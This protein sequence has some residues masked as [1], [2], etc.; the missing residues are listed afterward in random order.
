MDYNALSCGCG[1]SLVP[2]I[3]GY[4]DTKMIEHARGGLIALGGCI[5]DRSVTH[6][7]YSC[8]KLYPTEF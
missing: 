1:G 7:C 2:V 3:Y 5:L 8:N 4:P 6:Y